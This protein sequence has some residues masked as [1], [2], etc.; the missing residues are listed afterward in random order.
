MEKPEVDSAEGLSPAINIG[1][2]TTNRSP[3]STV[4]IV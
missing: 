4:G 3:L 2:K 1:P